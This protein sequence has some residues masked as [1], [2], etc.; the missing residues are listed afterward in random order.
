MLVIGA[1]HSS[2]S[3]KLYNICKEHC[4]HTYFIQTANELKSEWLT[5]A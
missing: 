5:D 1:A 4:D 3:Q 2:N